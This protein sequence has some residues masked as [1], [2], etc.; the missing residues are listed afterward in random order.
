MVQLSEMDKF[1]IDVQ[2]QINYMVSKYQEFVAK[3]HLLED[4]NK[5]LYLENQKLNEK[6]ISLSQDIKTLSSHTHSTYENLRVHEKFHDI[7][8][9]KLECADKFSTDMN[10]H[11]EQ[12]FSE[13]EKILNVHRDKLISFELK[14]NEIVRRIEVIS[15]SIKVLYSKLEDTDRKNE[16]LS[17]EINKQKLVL[18]SIERSISIIHNYID[19]IKKQIP[20]FNDSIHDSMKKLE[21]RNNAILSDIRETV[22]KSKHTINESINKIKVPSI[23][24]LASLEDIKK[25]HSQLESIALDAKNAFLK[26]SNNDMQILL[27]NKK[28]ESVS[29][30][31]KSIEL[32]K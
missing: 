2:N 20:Q 15:H 30:A 10:T 23:D 6:I 18:D 14:Q 25:I 32:T 28:I 11:I 9:K 17:L 26:S 8:E 24:G 4:E 13:N 27:M 16:S 29:I 12:S 22:E 5:K 3:F 21:D 19:G 31:Q 1:K 7:F